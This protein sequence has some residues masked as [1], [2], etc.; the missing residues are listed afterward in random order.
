ML[1][2]ILLISIIV[3]SILRSLKNAIHT[4]ELVGFFP[5]ILLIHIVFVN[6]SLSYILDNESF[7]WF[8]LVL[9]S[10]MSTPG[11]KLRSL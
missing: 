1:G 5:I 11:E 9:V 8:L 10:F 4:H 3:I 2:V 6:F 7:L